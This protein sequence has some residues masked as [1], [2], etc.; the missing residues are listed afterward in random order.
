[1]REVW[2]ERVRQPFVVWNVHERM[3]ELA[4]TTVMT[5]VVRLADKGLLQVERLPG[6]RAL[7]YRS[8]GTPGEYLTWASNRHAQE[9]VS[10]FGDA[11]LAAFETQLDRL[12]ADQ[13]RRLREVDER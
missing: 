7:Q 4:Y 3:P 5:T 1:M 12:T 9:L 13:R 10:R 2:S 8:A 6:Q 11:A